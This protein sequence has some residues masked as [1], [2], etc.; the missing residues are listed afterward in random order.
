MAQLKTIDETLYYLENGKV[1]FTPEYHIKRGSCCGNKCRHCAFEPKYIK[2]NTI[3]SEYYEREEIG[4]G[5][6]SE[7][8][9]SIAKEA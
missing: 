9:T 4:H 6:S 2:G 3:K 7:E 1:V 5:Q 8:A